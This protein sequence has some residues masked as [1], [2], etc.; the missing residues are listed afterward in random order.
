MALRRPPT[1]VELKNDDIEEYDTLMLE[2]AK[3]AAKAKGKASGKKQ[4]TRTSDAYSFSE[5][6]SAFHQQKPTAKER[7]GI[8]RNR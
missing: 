4:Q 8:G 6:D 5:A 1:R 7:I 3:E 2:R